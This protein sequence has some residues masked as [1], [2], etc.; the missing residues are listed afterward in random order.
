MYT[1]KGKGYASWTG[2]LPACSQIHSQSSL[3]LPISQGLHC[4]GSLDKWHLT[5]LGKWEALLGYMQVG[6][7]K[8]PG[9]LALSFFA[10]VASLSVAISSMTSAPMGQSF[11]CISDLTRLPLRGS[12]SYYI[13]Q[14]LSFGNTLSS[15]HSIHQND[16][17][18]S[19]L[20]PTSGLSQYLLIWLLSSSITCVMNTLHWISSVCVYPEWFLLPWMAPYWYSL[21]T[22]NGHRRLILNME[23]GLSYHLFDKCSEDLT[24]VI[25]GISDIIVTSTISCVFLRQSTG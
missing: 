18:S 1:V 8:K 25:C 13:A 20:F 10:L 17:S 6:E 15:L 14:F 22:G 3:V 11:L 5:R 21:H 4:P 16:G 12:S 9:Y 2:H 7:E 24:L 19:L 23:L